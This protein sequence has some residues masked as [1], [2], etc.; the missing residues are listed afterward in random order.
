MAEKLWAAKGETHEDH[1]EAP[2][3]K[4]VGPGEEFRNACC[5]R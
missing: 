3:E 4:Q 1:S 2:C 5:A